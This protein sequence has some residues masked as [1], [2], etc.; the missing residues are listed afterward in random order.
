MERSLAPGL[1]DAIASL[2]RQAHIRMH[3]VSS[4]DNVL[5]RSAVP[6][7]AR[8]PDRAMYRDRA[9]TRSAQIAPTTS[10]MHR[11]CPRL[12]RAVRVRATEWNVIQP[13]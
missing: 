9:R 11:S 4:A 3:A 12:P 7:T 8:A 1:Y 10:G 5:G 2:Y 6:A 13:H